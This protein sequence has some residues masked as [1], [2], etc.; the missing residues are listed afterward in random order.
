MQEA[1]LSE[2]I[3][4][5]KFTV[6]MAYAMLGGAAITITACGDG[7]SP[8]GSN[9]GPYG[10][11]TATPT[12]AATGVTVGAIGNNH[13]HAAVITGAQLDAG[14]GLTLDIKGSAPHAHTVTL[15]GDQVA[16]IKGGQ[17]VTVESTVADG[18]STYGGVH[19]HNV[20]FN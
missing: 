2:T 1:K 20:T 13:G 6:A 14:G 7:G 4:R 17:T 3:D 15:T 18:G 11:P 12:A 9:G 19:T 16:N 5:R 8:T 10:N